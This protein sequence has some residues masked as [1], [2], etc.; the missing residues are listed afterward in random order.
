MCFF[1]PSGYAFKHAAVSGQEEQE[2]LVEEVVTKAPGKKIRRVDLTAR[3]LDTSLLKEGGNVKFGGN[4]SSKIIGTGTIGNSFISINNVWLI[5]GLEHN[6]LSIS[7]FC[8]NG[9]NVMF[10][11]TNST[12][13][14]KDN[15]FIVFK[16]KIVENV[17]VI[18]QILTRIPPSNCIFIVYL[19]FILF[20]VFSFIHFSFACFIVF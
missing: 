8:D 18:P 12:V 16:G 10:E 4:Q 20:V 5:D 1:S 14:N 7:Q 2:F 13:I 9:Y 3:S 11:K 15:K 6:L 19:K 17:Y